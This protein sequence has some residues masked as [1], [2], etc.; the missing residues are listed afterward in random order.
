[1]SNSVVPVNL[2]KYIDHS[3]M[4][5][6]PPVLVFIMESGEKIIKTGQEA[7]DTEDELDRI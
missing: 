1:M 5:E 6:Q 7:I 3:G 2:I 4:G